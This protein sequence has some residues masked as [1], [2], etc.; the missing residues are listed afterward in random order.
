M[1]S[2]RWR[3]PEDHK[4]SLFAMPG[5]PKRV[6]TEGSFTLSVVLKDGTTGQPVPEVTVYGVG[7]AGVAYQAVTDQDGKASLQTLESSL[8]Q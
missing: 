6:P 2:I 4:L 7:E 1:T 3:S 8:L 5:I